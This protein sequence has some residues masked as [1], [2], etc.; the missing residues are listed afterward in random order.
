MSDHENP[1]GSVSTLKQK[2][3]EALQTTIAETGGDTSSQV[4][5]VRQTKLESKVLELKPRDNLLPD[6]KSVY[7]MLAGEEE[8]EEVLPEEL[9][10][11]RT[12]LTSEL[13]QAQ[14][15]QNLFQEKEAKKTKFDDTLSKRGVVPDA[16]KEK[17]HP[18]CAPS[19]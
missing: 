4:G 8:A 7:G 14:K 6:G 19:Y 9:Q 17:Y 2:L 1:T 18:D 13:Q 10:E 3:L 12:R 5:E 15:A 16:Q 11:S